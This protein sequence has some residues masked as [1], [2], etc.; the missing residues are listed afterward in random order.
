MH[1]AE[2]VFYYAYIEYKAIFIKQVVQSY[3]VL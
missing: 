3:S 2:Y 1:N